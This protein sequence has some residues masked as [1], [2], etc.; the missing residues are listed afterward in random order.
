M[1]LLATLAALVWPAPEAEIHKNPCDR[2]CRQ[3]KRLARAQ[4]RRE[5]RWRNFIEPYRYWLASVRSCE[6]R[7]HANPYIVNTG[8]GFYGAYQFTLS[9]WYAV[10]GQGY[11]HHAPPLEQDYRAVRLLHVQGPGGW[12][13]CG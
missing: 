9:S 8:N 13:V 5:R 12:P 2:H 7:G 3:K 4:A 11:P 6:T 10:G 1:T